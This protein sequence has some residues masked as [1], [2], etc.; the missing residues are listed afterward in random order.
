MRKNLSDTFL[1]GLAAC[2]AAIAAAP[3]DANAWEERARFRAS[4]RDETANIIADCRAALALRPREKTPK[5][6][7][8]MAEAREAMN[9][10]TRQNGGLRLYFAARAIAY[11]EVALELTSQQTPILELRAVAW[12]YLGELELS[13][14][15]FDDLRARRGTT[16]RS[17]EAQAALF[18]E[19]FDFRVASEIYRQAIRAGA[20]EGRWKLT[21]ELCLNRAL[22]D[23]SRNHHQL[24][25]LDSAVE[26]APDSA[27][28]LIERAQWE[29]R[30]SNRERALADFDMAVQL[31]PQFPETF[32]AR[33]DC[34]ATLRVERD[35]PWFLAAS[36]DYARALRLRIAA[37]E[38]AASGLE[39]YRL[40]VKNNA[41]KRE[42]TQLTRAHAILSVAL[43]YEPHKA[44]FYARRALVLWQLEGLRRYVSSR[45]G[46]VQ[47]RDERLQKAAFAD[48][49]CAV[50]LEPHS[51]KY[52]A[53]LAQFFVAPLQGQSAHQKAEGLLQAR[54]TLGEFGLN[55]AL[56]AEIMGEIEA[57]ICET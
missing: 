57:R 43:E 23:E 56:I 40:A 6:N 45:F 22:S 34:I 10:A 39:M 16:S 2:D 30:A 8:L 55:E 28:P 38:F 26:I 5:L 33:A 49:L 35:E 46:F 41:Y 24:A 32:Q 20:R 29:A 12:A 15:D 53:Q 3:L 36:N 42:P 52:R 17:F 27:R 48:E 4:Q 37:G 7:E 44:S 25:W 18:A 50:Q 13:R 19:N 11:F 54:A 31:A 21:A 51:N 47:E 14:A 9:R 1:S